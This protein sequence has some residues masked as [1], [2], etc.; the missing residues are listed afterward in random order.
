MKPR[1]FHSELLR[2]ARFRAFRIAPRGPSLRG[3]LPFFLTAAAFVFA[4]RTGLAQSVPAP[5]PSVAESLASEIRSVFERTK[6]SVVR[7]EATDHHSPLS[8]TGFFVDPAGVIYTSYTIG[9]ETTDIV[10]CSGNGKMPARRLFADPRSGV[11]VLKVDSETPFISVGKSRALSIGSPMVVVGYPMALSVTPSFGTVAG[12]DMM[13]AGRY[14]ATRHIRCNVPVQRGQGGAPVLNMQGEAVGIVIASID[15]GSACFTIPIEAA[16]KL[17]K[18]YM[19]F[20]EMRPGWMGVGIETA[21]SRTAGSTAE[22]SMLNLGSPGAKA[23]L[24]SGDVILQINDHAITSPEDVLDA[25]FFI[26]AEDDVAIKVARGDEQLDFQVT[27]GN[28]PNTNARTAGDIPTFAPGNS[29][30]L[31]GLPMTIDGGR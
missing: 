24:R 17:R 6:K 4:E 2:C 11:A 5:A 8:G 25:S 22:V 20:G 15:N 3:C 18:D 12:F 31:R 19:R 16:E 29:E 1:R 28:R 26:A 30:D 23:G 27:A 14:F 13:Y 10:V 7:I 9:G 21:R